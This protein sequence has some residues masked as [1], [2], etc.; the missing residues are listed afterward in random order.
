VALGV[1]FVHL[2]AHCAVRAMIRYSNPGTDRN[3]NAGV[4]RNRIHCELQSLTRGESQTFSSESRI[5]TIAADGVLSGGTTSGT[6]AIEFS[7]SWGCSIRVA[8]SIAVKSRAPA[9]K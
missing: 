9:R 3:R 6:G 2:A 7:G 4:T 5:G 1:H 8:M